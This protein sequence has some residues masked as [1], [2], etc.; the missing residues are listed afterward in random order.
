MKNLKVASLS[1][2]SFMI[3]IYA[4][5][6]PAEQLKQMNKAP[7]WVLA[8]K[9][10]KASKILKK[11]YPYLAGWLD[12]NAKSPE[13]YVIDLFKK[14]QIV[15]FG[16]FHNVKEH[17]DFVIDL[18]PRLYHEAGVRYVG[19]EFS[20]NTDNKQLE[21]LVMAPEFDREAAL[22]F[23]RNQ[24]AHEWN[25]KEHWDIIEAVWRLNNNLKPSQERMRF[26][27]LDK[28]VDFVRLMIAMKTKG[29]D[30]QESQEVIA[31]AIK[32][33]NVMAEQ[34]RKEIVEKGKKGL[35]FVGRCHDFTH[36]EFPPEVNFGRPIMG[37]LLYKKYGDRVFQ[38]WL[39]SGWLPP[40]EGVMKPRGHKPAGF[41]LHA[42]PFANI[43]SPPNWDAPEV[44]LSKIARG[45]IYFGPR[46]KLH[47]N[48]PIKGFV[49]DEMFKKYKQY[50][51]ID[52]GRKFKN[53]EEVDKYFQAHRFPKP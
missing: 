23:A 52:F 29:E 4:A 35:V 9:P 30:S 3:F 25:S 49:T 19:W 11:D 5:L 15:I 24:L 36:Y 46:A 18:I 1:V 10:I 33:D 26:I 41:D 48:T 38:V 16:E 34:V 12:K 17:K 39:A 50:Y 44:P 22:E 20:R 21:K 32:R 42:S 45:Y 43:L 7:D 53:A 28:D 8:G 6:S 37:N 31:E 47:K 27:G 51:E 14:H 2:F 40:F 13:D